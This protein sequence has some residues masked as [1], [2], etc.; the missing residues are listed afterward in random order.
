MITHTDLMAEITTL[1]H[2]TQALVSTHEQY[3][4]IITK[5]HEEKVAELT[6]KLAAA[7]AK[8]A[9]LER[10]RTVDLTSE[11]TSRQK[12]ETF[13]EI[14]E[15]V[16][17]F[18]S[19]NSCVCISFMYWNHMISIRANTVNTKWDTITIEAF[20]GLIL[21]VHVLDNDMKKWRQLYITQDQIISTLES[22]I[23]GTFL[24]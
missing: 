16:K 24:Q 13:H 11:S 4:E 23:A 5:K 15:I 7:E 20:D 9:E 8:I 19:D 10:L 3:L 6:A 1:L 21:S 22:I 2:V 14:K 18:V 12:Y 17:K